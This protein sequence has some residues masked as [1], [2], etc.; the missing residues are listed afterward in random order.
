MRPPARQTYFGHASR[1]PLIDRRRHSRTRAQR[2]KEA[3]TPLSCAERAARQIRVA[4]STRSKIV[5]S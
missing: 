1:L 2:D 5:S 4:L 3:Q